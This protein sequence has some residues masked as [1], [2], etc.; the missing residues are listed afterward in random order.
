MSADIAYGL[1]FQWTV[2][3]C[4]QVKQCVDSKHLFNSQMSQSSNKVFDQY[5][6]TKN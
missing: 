6:R 1:I 5:T 4:A 2:L 3:A